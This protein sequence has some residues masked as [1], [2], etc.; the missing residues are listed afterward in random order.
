MFF[1]NIEDVKIAF[2]VAEKKRGR[3]DFI[4]AY[5]H[6]FQILSD[7]V[8]QGLPQWSHSITANIIQAI[9]HL[10]SSIGNFET[11]DNLL[12]VLVELYRSTGNQ[13]FANFTLIKC[14]HLELDRGNFRRVH[15]LF[16]SLDPQVSN[17]ENINICPD[18]L[19]QWEVDCLWENADISE[20]SVLFAHFYL[21][22]G[23]FLSASGQYGDA[24][25]ILDRGLWHTRSET[26][27]LARQIAL[28]FH[29]SIASAYLERGELDKA[30]TKLAEPQTNNFDPDLDPEFKVCSLE[31][32]G[33]I[34]L[35]QGNLG[36]ALDRFEQVRDICLDLGLTQ[37]FGR[38]VLNLAEFLISINQTNL[39]S[40]YLNESLLCELSKRDLNLTNRR[41]LL[42][43]LMEARNESLVCDV[44]SNRARSNISSTVIKSNNDPANNQLEGLE[45]SPQSSN[46]LAHFELRALQFRWRLSRSELGQANQLLSNI[47][48]AFGQSDSPLIQIRI[49][50]LIGTLAYYQGI[51]YQESVRFNWAAS[52]L[53]ELRSDLKQMG[54]KPD[55]WQVQ[56]ILSW[57][58][59][60]VKIDK[61]LQAEI[62]DSNDNLLDQFTRSLKPDHQSIYLL[63]KWTANEECIGAKIQN[64][65]Q[66]KLNSY[67]SWKSLKCLPS[68]QFKYWQKLKLIQKL[69]ELILY[70][71]RYKDALAKKITRDSL[72][73]HKSSIYSAWK[74]IFTHSRD[75]IT[76]IF[77][78]L[79]DQI[80]IIR[81]GWLLFDYQ[82][83][84]T[85]R[86]ELRNLVQGL[87]KRIQGFS[88]KFVCTEDYNMIDFHLDEQLDTNRA[89]SK[90]LS[91]IL[92]INLLLKGLP[93]RVKSISIIPDDILH[94]VPFA[95]LTHE[96]NH[97]IQKYSISI[98]YE[99]QHPKQVKSARSLAMQSLL[100]GIS[101]DDR[102]LVNVEPEITQIKSWMNQQQLN[103]LSLMDIAADKANIIKELCRSSFFHIACH[104][105][106]DHDHP[107]LS[108]LELISNS[109]QSKEILSLKELSKLDLKELR[110]ATLSS[111]W[112]ADHFILPGRWIISFPETFLRAGTESILGCLWE[113][114]DFVAL[115]FMTRF[116]EN[117][118]KY[119]RDKALQLTQQ[120]CIEGRLIP[121]KDLSNPLYWAGFTLYGNH[122]KL[123]LRTRAKN[124]LRSIV[125]S[126]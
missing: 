87:H 111:C 45:F 103:P 81:I 23:R 38:S 58:W 104:G 102:P 100:I 116:Y 110:H 57:C 69:D 88:R 32:V 30:L 83:A 53:E 82:I 119:P 71:E 17:I 78:V 24:L 115:S 33:R 56:R 40:E 60:K 73:N 80:L 90:R 61:S 43:E 21:A 15:E 44:S 106:F 9:V 99:S 91:E 34:L 46:Y 67:I 22:M 84:P 31:L 89:I 113:V 47:Q 6:Y 49:K 85:T 126:S 118:E 18:G 35:L 19:I 13:P 42:L 75:R 114:N 117:T 2:E 124:N 28:F 12:S 1:R 93:K 36:Q 27:A 8:N 62:R 7:L 10:S 26:P 39:A 74:R 3:G 108:G 54:L 5:S 51:R 77:V 95:V 98:S 70:I 52:T 76:L 125:L 120:D 20:R 101:P 4:G 29:F 109:K 48:S 92:K 50:I 112:S 122:K 97:L 94:G 72:P 66:L 14:I 79:P 64:I 41:E 105:F 107:D 59:S 11:A 65:N 25:I 96:N 68:I 63:N 123:D 16:Q 37:A 86:L 55:L 121:T